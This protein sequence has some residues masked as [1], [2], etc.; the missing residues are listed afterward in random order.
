MEEGMQVGVHDHQEWQVLSLVPTMD[1][2]DQ[3]LGPVHALV[4]G[5]QA[6]P[7]IIFK[8]EQKLHNWV[9]QFCY[10]L[11]LLPESGIKG[12]FLNL[13]TIICFGES[14]GGPFCRLEHSPED[15]SVFEKAA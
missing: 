11:D 9:C 2:L 10:V 1:F 8:F 7:T 15:V 14:G 3:E 6:Y 4:D 12:D 5:P 13:L